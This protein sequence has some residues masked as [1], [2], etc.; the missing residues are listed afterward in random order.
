MYTEDFSFINDVPIH[1]VTEEEIKDI[2]SL[3]SKYR[4]QFEI[5]VEPL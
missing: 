5:L 3:V 2:S 1:F 4:Y